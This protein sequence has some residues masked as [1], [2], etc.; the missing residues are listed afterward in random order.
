MATTNDPIS[1]YLTRVRNA[2]LARHESMK[3]PK[4]KMLTCISQILHEEGYV[5]GYEEIHEG[6]QDSLLVHL[7]Y[8]PDRSNAITKLIRVSKP[9]RRRYV[10]AREIPRVKNGLGTA[11]LS[12]SMGVMTGRKAR[13]NNVG[14]EVLCTIW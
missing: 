14:G 2:I 4:S 9:S 10:G 13:E 11:I 8:L 5:D 12:T 1:D 6:I 3:V 7:R